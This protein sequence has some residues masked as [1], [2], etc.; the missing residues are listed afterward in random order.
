MCVAGTGGLFIYNSINLIGKPE[1]K[2]W[3]IKIIQFLG[4][5]EKSTMLIGACK[6]VLRN[7]KAFEDCAS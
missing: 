1:K 5:Y 2:S 7:G 6:N 4:R 3:K